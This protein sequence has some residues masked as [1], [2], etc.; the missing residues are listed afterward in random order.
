MNKTG[1]IHYETAR[2]PNSYSADTALQK[3]FLIFND[4]ISKWHKPK[5]SKENVELYIYRNF[6]S[7]ETI[8]VFGFLD[9]LAYKFLPIQTRNWRMTNQTANVLGYIC[10]KA[11][12]FDDSGK[13]ARE[14]YYTEEIPYPIGPEQYFGLNGAILKVDNVKTGEILFEATAIEFRRFN[15][16]KF[17]KPKIEKMLNENEFQKIVEAF[18]VK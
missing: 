14:L 16:S 6:R 1:I 4:S 15:K 17:D 8:K 10:K 9:Y 12:I 7:K 3:S 5:N 18:S 13:P 2:Y 11:I